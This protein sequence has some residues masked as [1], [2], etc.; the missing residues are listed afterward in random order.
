MSTSLKNMTEAEA[1]LYT[2]SEAAILMSIEKL[3]ASYKREP[4]PETLALVDALE[5]TFREE[6]LRTF[7][8]NTAKIAD[9]L[10]QRLPRLTK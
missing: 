7:K 2:P 10:F 1:A 8:S 4:K 3:M 9:N 6:T 5:E